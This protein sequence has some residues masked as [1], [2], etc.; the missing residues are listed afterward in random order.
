MA[1]VRVKPA[2]SPVTR[3]YPVAQRTPAAAEPHFRRE[4]EH[5][6]K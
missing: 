6:A 2:V 1:H 4:I 5:W 3:L